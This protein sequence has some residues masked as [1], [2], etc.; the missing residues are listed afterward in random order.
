MGRPRRKAGARM[1]DLPSGP[2]SA[3]RFGYSV[4]Q[5]KRRLRFPVQVIGIRRGDGDVGARRRDHAHS[6]L[7]ASTTT[8][9]PHGCYGASRFAVNSISTLT[10]PTRTRRCD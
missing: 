3:S 1:F 4:T 2:A 7:A 8:A 5:D 10:W 9:V 6:E